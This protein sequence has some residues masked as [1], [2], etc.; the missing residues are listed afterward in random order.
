MSA[1][2]IS[3]IVFAAFAVIL[4]ISFIVVCLILSKAGILK[5]AELERWEGRNG[6]D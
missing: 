1:L 3:M 4:S 2:E 5:D 6:Q